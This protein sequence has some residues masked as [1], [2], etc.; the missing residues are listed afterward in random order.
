MK[1]KIKVIFTCHNRKEKT[2]RCLKTLVEKNPKIE[3][4]FIIVDDNSQD[5]TVSSIKKL[6]LKTVIL[7]G[8]GNLFWSRGM[9][10]GIGYYINNCKS[11]FILLINDDVEFFS[12]SIEKILKK[13]INTQ[14]V[15]VGATCDKRGQYTYGAVKI[16][17]QVFRHLYYS[18]K[19]G[20][21]I[22]YCDT[23][24]ANCVLLRDEVLRRVGN[25]DSCYHHSMADFDYG[26]MIS[27]KGYKILSS[28][29]YI[30]LCN[31]NSLKGGWTDK[32]LSRLE[33]LKKKE[34][35]K[36][37][38]FREWFHFLKKNFGIFLAIRYSISPYIR[39]LIKR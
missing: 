25:F 37:L 38:P 21:G 32:S 1:I 34:S 7:N 29:E 28:N 3:F 17:K 15:I 30:G 36:G 11:D 9:R 39:I 13:A 20:D 10:M 16:N 12:N 27:K 14:S 8:G 23:F 19:P 5:D 31:R 24:N 33:R 2:I 26:F 18:V 22:V 35:I 6:N 4:S